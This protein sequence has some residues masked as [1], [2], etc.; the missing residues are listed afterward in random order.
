METTE[1]LTTEDIRNMNLD[2]FLKYKSSSLRPLSL[3][4]LC[5]ANREW[6]F[7]NLLTNT[8]TIKE[9][10]YHVKQRKEDLWWKIKHD[11]KTLGA[12]QISTMLQ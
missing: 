11:N 7:L 5:E 6:T 1:L 10:Q 12:A 9:L 3:Q 8:E 2:E 4:K